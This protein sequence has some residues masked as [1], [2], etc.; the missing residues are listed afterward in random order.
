MLEL[1]MKRRQEL[2]LKRN[3]LKNLLNGLKP[4]QIAKRRKVAKQIKEV[5]NSIARLGLQIR[6]LQKPAF[7][8][9]IQPLTQKVTPQL[10]AQFQTKQDP[11]VFKP[12][13]ISV[14][15]TMPQVD[16]PI[17]TVQSMPKFQ[18]ADQFLDENK[19]FKP[20]GYEQEFQAEEPIVLE[21]EVTEISTEDQGFDLMAFVDENK[22]LLGGGIALGLFFMLKP[23][24][25]RSNPKRRKAKAKR[26]TRRNKRRS[27]YHRS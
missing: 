23:K 9:G 4:V 8:S 13:A 18:K 2:I 10:P 17:R 27:G 14:I 6:K 19:G 12:S 11:T 1:L 25:A 20:K 16:L 26:K 21:E 24:K 15:E 22:W 7:R 5:N 3:V